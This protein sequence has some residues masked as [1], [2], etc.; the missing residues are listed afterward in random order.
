[1]M[2]VRQA[3]PEDVTA[4]VA[5]AEARRDAYEAYEPRFWKKSPDSAAACRTW[6]ET[7]FSDGRSM[8]FVAE[9][10]GTIL[11][12][13]IGRGFPTPPVYDPG[14]ATAMI[15]D[16]CVVSADRWGDVGR[17]LLRDIRAEMRRQGFA[18]VV[19]VSARRD[20]E[21]TAFLEEAGLSLAS[22]WWTSAI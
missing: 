3:T 2:N 19:V 6:F 14:G 7:L 9:E 17:A 18:Q 22:T 12:F 5:L 11:G 10:A 13:V 20:L 15:D 4:C 8:C 21:K 1:M 16:F